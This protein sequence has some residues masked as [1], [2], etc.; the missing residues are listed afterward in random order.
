MEYIGADLH[1]AF[2]AAVNSIREQFGDADIGR[3]E[4]RVQSSGRTMTDAN[5]V[6]IEYVCCAEYES[7]VRGNCLENV[8]EEVLRR[9]GW[10]NRNAPLSLPHSL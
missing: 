5:E 7:D 4:F 6:K 8:V 10:N 3:F 9:R 2:V 1:A